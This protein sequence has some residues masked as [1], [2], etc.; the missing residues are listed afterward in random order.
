M[1]SP[2]LSIQLNPFLFH[3]MIIYVLY[4][5]I[6]QFKPAMPG[7]IKLQAVVNDY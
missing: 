4:F 5:I 7:I 3:N 1:E 6:H 2:V